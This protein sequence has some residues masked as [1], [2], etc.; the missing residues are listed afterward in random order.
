VSQ[1]HQGGPGAARSV[2]RCI[3]RPRQAELARLRELN[4][5]LKIE[6]TDPWPDSR[7]VRVLDLT[8]V[9][10]GPWCTQVLADL[11]ADVIKIERPGGGD[12]TRRV[13][14]FVVGADG[15]PDQ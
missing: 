12:D 10:A 14:P 5:T 4:K 1:L 15:R 9:V 8:R 3:R 11:G 2:G 13:S 6:W 7:I